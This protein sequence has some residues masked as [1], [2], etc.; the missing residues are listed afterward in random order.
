MTIDPLHDRVLLRRIQAEEVTAGG[1]I[2]PSVAQEKSQECE[3]VAVGPGPYTSD[4]VRLGMTVK[5][6]DRVL[7]GKYSGTDTKVDGEE[8]IFVREPDILGVIHR[9]EVPA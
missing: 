6:G 4:G 1:I 5:P 9:A 8:M 3:V 2:I 7:L